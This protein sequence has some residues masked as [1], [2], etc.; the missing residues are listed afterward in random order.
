MFVVTQFVDKYAPTGVRCHVNWRPKK[1][2]EEAERATK[3]A[4]GDF[5]MELKLPVLFEIMAS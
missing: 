2:N 1:A 4:A 5:S 3:Y